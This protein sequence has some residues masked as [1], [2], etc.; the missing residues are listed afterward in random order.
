[1]AEGMSDWWSGY[2]DGRLLG[3]HLPVW[4]AADLALRRERA[5]PVAER[6]DDYWHGTRLGLT[7][8]L[9]ARQ[10][11]WRTY[12]GVRDRETP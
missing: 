11:T 9:D 7:D 1:M 4:S 12:A 2:Q 10:S 8:A 5:A 6:H 3:E